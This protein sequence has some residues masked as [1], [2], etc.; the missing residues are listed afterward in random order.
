MLL[1]SMGTSKHSVHIY[2]QAKHWHTENKNNVFKKEVGS[3]MK[4]RNEKRKGE[5]QAHES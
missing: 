2:I 1:I 4:R 3:D 5:D